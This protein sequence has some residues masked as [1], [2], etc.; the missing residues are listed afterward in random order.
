M[1]ERDARAAGVEL[2]TYHVPLSQVNR[3]VT[4]GEDE[5]FVRVHVR[6]GSAEILGATIVAATRAR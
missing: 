6:K 3:A 5:G 2:D 1:Y 4:D